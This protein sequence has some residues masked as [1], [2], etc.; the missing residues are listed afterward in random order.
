VNTAET[1]NIVWPLAFIL[2]FLIALRQFRNDARPIVS[3]IITG[4]S[5][6]AT[7]NATQYAIAIGFGLSASLSA[8]YD[9]FNDLSAANLSA[10]SWHQYA[11]LWAKIANP[12]IVAVLAYATQSNFGPKPPTSTGTTTPPIP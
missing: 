7:R 8:F 11:A 3:G 5:A 2:V 6:N 9:V 1:Q 12:F 4:L 10:I